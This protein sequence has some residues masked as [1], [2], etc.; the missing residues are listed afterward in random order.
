MKSFKEIQ[1][2]C[3]ENRRMTSVVIDDFLLFYAAAQYDLVRGMNRRFASYSHVTD[4]FQKEWVDMLKAQYIAHKIFRKGGLIKK[5]LNHSALKDL[6]KK[7]RDFLERQAQRPWRFS[8]GV[9][10]EQ[11]A[12]DFFIMED[13]FTGGEYLLYSPGVSDILRERSVRIWFNLLSDNGACW[14]SYGPIGAYSSFVPDDIYFFATEV[15]PEIEYDEEVL[16]DVERDPLPYMMLLAGSAYPVTVHKRDE[17]I[18]TIA[19]YELNAL[20][21]IALSKSFKR[22]YNAGVYRLSLKGKDGPPHFSQA[23]FDEKEQLLLLTAMTDRGFQALVRNMNKYGFHFSE[24]PFVRVHPSMLILTQDIL[25]REI[26]LDK[27]ETLFTIESSEEEDQMLDNLNYFMQL[28]LDDV[29]EGREPDIEALA[30]QAGVDEE[31]A[32]DFFQMMMKKFKDMDKNYPE[33]K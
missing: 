26:T 33:R 16:D 32:R 1:A 7:E 21:T 30:G 15:N 25:K 19:E 27:Y 6:L 29:N 10:R 4:K 22:E 23:Y 14:Q 2:I 24:E 20:D 28:A 13:V 8:F 3:E 12:K 9:I 31:T 11:P 18:M 17:I 5:L